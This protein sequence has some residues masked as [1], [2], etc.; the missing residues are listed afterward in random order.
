[1]TKIY[2]T[3]PYF[4]VPEADLLFSEPESL[5]KHLQK[6][7]KGSEYLKCPAFID[8]VKNTYIIKAPV[9]FE[10]IISDAK[11]KQI[12]INGLHQCFRNKFIDNTK[13]KGDN[14]TSPYI[15][16]V[17]PK[18]LFYSGQS[19]HMEVMQA[20]LETN[21]SVS[22]IMLI[23][24]TFDISKWIRPIDFTFEIKNENKITYI[25]KDDVIFYV[26]FK[27]ED[28]SKVELERVEPD[29]RLIHGF[30]A[31]VN[32]KNHVKGVPLKTLYKMA[33]SFLSTFSFKKPKKCPFGF[34][35]K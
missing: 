8:Y 2:W 15:L 26:K 29:P 5:L 25:K 27:T 21:D 9:D 18:Y 6:T 35:K 31:C 32:I 4:D 13:G 16:S 22:N 20:F 1:M 3:I 33:E 7:R 23:P 34:G 10:I 11:N 24:G 12:V 28:D 30:W 19:V 17:P 14:F